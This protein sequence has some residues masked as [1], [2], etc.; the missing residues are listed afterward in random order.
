MVMQLLA[1]TGAPNRVE[2]VFPYLGRLREDLRGVATGAPGPLE[3]NR[4]AACW[5]L[6]AWGDRR[7]EDLRAIL[8]P[9]NPTLREAPPGVAGATL[10]AL[11]TAWAD[12]H[13][14]AEGAKKPWTW[15]YCAPPTL[16]PTGTHAM[17][18]F[19]VRYAHWAYE[20]VLYL[21][22]DSESWRLRSVENGWIT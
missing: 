15:H 6:L 14:R 18:K 8:A 2:A 10:E 22:R 7:D 19:E 5:L 1:A 17:M 4:Q 20:L 13:F 11:C 9:R 21:V 3:G 12:V 16:D